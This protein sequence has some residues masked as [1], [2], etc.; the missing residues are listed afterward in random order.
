MSRRSTIRGVSR[1]SIHSDDDGRN[2]CRDPRWLRETQAM[3]VRQNDSGRGRDHFGHGWMQ[4]T[5]IEEMGRTDMN[6]FT[7]CLSAVDPMATQSLFSVSSDEND[8]WD[9]EQ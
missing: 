7:A 9:Y 4:C 8:G 1:A 5:D 2:G 6:G 3:T